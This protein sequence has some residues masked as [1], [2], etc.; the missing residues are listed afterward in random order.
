ME[1]LNGLEDMLK[2]KNIKFM[3]IDGS[4]TKEKRHENVMKFQ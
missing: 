4:V 1:V 3:R 2:A